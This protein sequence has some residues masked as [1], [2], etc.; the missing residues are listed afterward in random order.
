MKR[1]TEKL[2]SEYCHYLVE[3]EKSAVTIEKYKRDISAFMHWLGEKRLDKSTVL[4][5]KECLKQTH[6]PASV[7]SVISSLNSFF[8]Y[9]EWHGLRVKCIKIQKQIFA[10]EG[11]LL[12]KKEYMRLLA[13]AQK[14]GDERLGLLMQTICATG[15]RVSELAFITVESLAKRQALI[16]LKGKNRVVII[17]D[18]LCRVLVKYARRKNIS[19]GSVFV[20][21]TGKPLD[22]SNIWKLMKSLCDS[23]GVVKEKVFPHNLRHLFART[24]YEVRKDIARLA[25]ILGHTS[26]NT[27]RIYTMETGETHRLQLQKLG[28]LRC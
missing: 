2:L 13:T 5:Y 14:N 20:T 7:N 18:E 6:A 22:R 15:I 19:S 27:T 10:G 24:F 9:N 11:K 23:A 17:P 28:L 8:G 1:I 16:S 21:K 26:I 25:D 4:E 12:T 3:E